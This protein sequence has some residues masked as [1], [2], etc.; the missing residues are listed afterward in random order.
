MPARP[1]VC[2]RA[3]TG[4]GARSGRVSSIMAILGGSVYYTWVKNQEVNRRDAEIAAYDR[5]PLEDVERG[6]KVVP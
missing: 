1:V 2:V 3:L 6:K 4:R 5:V